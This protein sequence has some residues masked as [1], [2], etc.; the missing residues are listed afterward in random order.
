M[1]PAKAGAGQL[2]P[3]SSAPAGIGPIDPSAGDLHPKPAAP[4]AEDGHAAAVMK[5]SDLAVS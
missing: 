2:P 3:A 4:T 1:H 5:L